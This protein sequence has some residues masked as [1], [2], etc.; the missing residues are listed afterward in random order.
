M[1][2][3]TCTACVVAASFSFPPF[4]S[5]STGETTK[6]PSLLVLIGNK[7]HFF[8]FPTTTLLN[9]TKT[10]PLTA[11]PNR[12]QLAEIKTKTKTT[13]PNTTTAAAASKSSLNPKQFPNRKTT[14]HE[15]HQNAI[16]FHI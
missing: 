15:S 11:T 7:P 1:L 8:F 6:S 10:Q 14:Q 13:S 4:F 16:N 9:R 2:T 12:F 5:A 3:A